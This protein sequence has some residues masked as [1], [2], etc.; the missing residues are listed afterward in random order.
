[1]EERE[2]SIAATPRCEFSGMNS[3]TIVLQMKT[4][5]RQEAKK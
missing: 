5:P 3:E 1:M 4:T 2:Y